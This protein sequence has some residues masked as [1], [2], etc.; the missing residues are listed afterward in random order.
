[1]TNNSLFNFTVDKPAQTVYIDMEF[2]ADVSLVW[3]AFTKAELLDQWYAPKPLVSKTK[4]M[5]FK[6]GGKRF[7]AMVWPDGKEMWALQTYKSISPKTNFKFFNVFADKDE[8][9]QPPGSD[10]DMNFSEENGMTKV[11][12][13]IYNESLERMEK[14]MDG[15]KLG[16]AATYENLKELLASLVVK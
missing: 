6:V 1:M 14:L 7:Y 10:W 3:D 12:I 15:F 16:M 2:D 11:S 5:D 4:Y 9:P 13:S 8:N